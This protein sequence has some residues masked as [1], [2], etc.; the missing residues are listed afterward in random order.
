MTG[1]DLIAAIARQEQSLV[2]DQFDEDIGVAVGSALHARAK[3]LGA[4]VVIEIKSGTRRFYF[5]ALPGS[6][7][8]NEDWA[9]RKGNVVRHCHMSSLRV[10]L[11]QSAQ[12]RTQ[13]PDGGLPYEDFVTHGGGFPV[14]VKAAGVV[15]SIA[16]SG[17]PSRQAHELITTTLAAYLGV[18]G[19]ADLILP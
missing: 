1:P 15:A 11:T 2:F 7:A 12:G 4:P 10:G 5:A 3:A 16:L 9:R 6:T 13:W 18:S 14:T 8:E 17:L 19:I